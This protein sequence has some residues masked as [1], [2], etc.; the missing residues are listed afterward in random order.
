MDVLI[1]YVLLFGVMY[2]PWFDF[3]MDPTAS[4]HQILYKFQ[5]K[6]DR[7]PGNY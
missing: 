2:L 1:S 3:S 5:E 7:T 4:V 6:C